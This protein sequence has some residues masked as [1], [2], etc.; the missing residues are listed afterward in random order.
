MSGKPRHMCAALPPVG[1]GAY[2]LAM[3]GFRL[4]NEERLLIGVV[5]HLFKV[6]TSI[7]HEPGYT[8]GDC[9]HVIFSHLGPRAE[10]RGEGIQVRRLR[11]G[12]E[13]YKLR[14]C[15]EVTVMFR[16]GS[17]SYVSRWI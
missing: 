11:T 13:R 6:G 17:V 8:M 4:L 15:S 5:S 3:R 7:L 1:Y 2:W 9:I 12:L 10:V 14:C 16:S